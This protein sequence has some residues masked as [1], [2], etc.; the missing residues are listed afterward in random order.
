MKVLLI[1]DPQKCFCPGGELGVQ[2]GAAVMPV[3]NRLMKEGGYDLVVVSQDWHPAGHKSF[4]SSHPGKKVFDT[5]LLNG[6]LQV[7]WP[8]H[9]VQDTPGAE[10]HP[11]L[12]VS[13]IN[14]VIRKGTDI[15]VDSYSAFRDNAKGRL[16]GLLNYLIIEAAGRGRDLH[17][18][19]LDVC[20]LALDYCV[21]FSA[22]DAAEFKLQTRVIVDATRAVD[23]REEAVLGVLSEMREAGIEIVESREVIARPRALTAGEERT[24]GRGLAVNV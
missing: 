1:V 22:L 19:K 12:I 14:R 5:V 17:D 8:D 2:D 3:I 24:A 16:T 18:I 23:Q 21:K 4:A 10:F 15:E 20:G 7:L 9:G 13:R 11:D 6:Q